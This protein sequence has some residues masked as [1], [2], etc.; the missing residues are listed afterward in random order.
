MP[1]RS[2]RPA[3]SLCAV[4][5]AITF[6]Q[7]PPSFAQSAAKPA[8]RVGELT[9]DRIYSQPSLSGR[10]TRGIA[11]TADGKKLSFF[12]IIGSGKDAKPALY[13]LDTATG[14]RALLLSAEKLES[15]LPP[16]DENKSQATGLG[17][18][19]PSQV[20]WGAFW[21]RAPIPGSEL[22]RV[23]RLEIAIRPRVGDGQGRTR[24]P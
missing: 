20:Q 16:P 18:R 10:L 9:V 17:R 3:L 22:S 24:R 8:H 23:V 21:R 19:A 12:E 2:L 5:L 1:A 13:A 6:F 11:W 4:I 15:V 14:A 7:A